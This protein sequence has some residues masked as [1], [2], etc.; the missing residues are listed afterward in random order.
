M[1]TK[2]KMLPLKVGNEYEY[3]LNNDKQQNPHLTIVG[4]DV[5]KTLN[6]L[7]FWNLPVLKFCLSK[8][9]LLF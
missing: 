4:A 9:V 1:L 8:L 3:H 6:L 5:K 7:L 2:K